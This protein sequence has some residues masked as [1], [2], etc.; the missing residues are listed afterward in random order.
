MNNNHIN[1]HSNMLNII[2]NLLSRF[3]RLS[4]W[5][6]SLS[7][8]SCWIAFL[9]QTCLLLWWNRFLL[10]GQYIRIRNIN[11]NITIFRWISR[12]NRRTTHCRVHSRICRGMMRVWVRLIG[13]FRM[14]WRWLGRRNW[15]ISNCQITTELSEFI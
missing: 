1:S 11:R 2:N 6:I 13:R 5:C 4:R 10:Q 9:N 3:R 15:G 7:N 8:Q 12:L 14:H